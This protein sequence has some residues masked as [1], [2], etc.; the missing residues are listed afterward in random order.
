MLKRHVEYTDSKKAKKILRHWE[1]SLPRFIKVLPMEYR[2]YLGQMMREDE[3]I[4]RD[5]KSSE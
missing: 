3:A 2:R 5:D 4:E 1:N